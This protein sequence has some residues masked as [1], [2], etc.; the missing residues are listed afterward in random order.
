[1]A[2][3]ENETRTRQAQCPTH[4]DVR[5]EKKVP[6]IK[7][8]FLVTAPARGLAALRPYRCPTCSAKAT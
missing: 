6:K 1:M 8:P 4:G 5:A 2:M 3:I 7:F